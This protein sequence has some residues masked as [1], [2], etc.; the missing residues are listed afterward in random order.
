MAEMTINEHVYSIGRL[1]PKQQLHLARRILPLFTGVGAAFDL[2][3]GVD[4]DFRQFG[5]FADALA[6]MTDAEVDAIIDPCLGVINRKVGE[7]WSPVMPRP[8][9]LMY[10]DLGV[11][12]M[13][14]LTWAVISENL[15]NFFP[16][17]IGKGP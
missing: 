3:K 5:P 16:A 12:E 10:Q 13:I 8:G 14:Q 9:Q 15:G 6:K 11:A 17:Q 1:T 2:D 4:T 7:L